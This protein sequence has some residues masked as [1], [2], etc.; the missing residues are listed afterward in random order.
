MSSEVDVSIL[1]H[2]RLKVMIVLKLTLL[3]VTDRSCGVHYIVGIA[4]LI[5]QPVLPVHLLY[6]RVDLKDAVVPPVVFALID[7]LI[8]KTNG[9]VV[10]L[11]H[12]KQSLPVFGHLECSVISLSSKGMF[13]GIHRAEVS[14]SSHFELSAYWEHSIDVSSILSQHVRDDTKP[15]AWGEGVHHRRVVSAPC[16]ERIRV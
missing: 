5:V 7:R 3:W 13:G 1:K 11:E 8:S 4:N 9:V 10:V 12:N 15:I 6:W 2:H 16:S 14:Q